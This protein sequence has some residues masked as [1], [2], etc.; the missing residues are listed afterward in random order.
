MWN[1]VSDEVDLPTLDAPLPDW[2]VGLCVQANVPAR[3]VAEILGRAGGILDADL[4]G[5]FDDA[6]VLAELGALEQVT[7]R[8]TIQ[9]PE[10]ILFAASPVTDRHGWGLPLTAAEMRRWR[11]TSW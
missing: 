5:R 8:Y 7:A 1:A 4:F 10:P 9:L 2:L 6:G 11:A 3:D